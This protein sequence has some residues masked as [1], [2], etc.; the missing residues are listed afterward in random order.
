MLKKRR[1]ARAV[2]PDHRGDP[3]SA[4]SK[5]SPSTATRPPKRLLTDSVALTTRLAALIVF[6]LRTLL[7]QLD[8]GAGAGGLPRADPVHLELSS[9]LRQQALGAQHH[10]DHQQEAE[11]PVAELGQV[12]V[13]ADVARD[14]VE[15]VGDQVA[16][17]ER[18]RH[19]A[20]HDAPDRSEPAEDDHGE[21]EDRERELEL[22]GV[23]RVQIGAEEGAGDPA[24]RRAGAVGRELRAHD[25]DPHAGRRRP[26]PRAARSTPARGASRAGG[27]S[28][29]ARSAPARGRR[30]TTSA[31]R[32]R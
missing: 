9:S 1:L 29:T 21:D 20:Q 26:R 11:D 32:A 8:V 30:S 23:D 10:H 2:G 31:G 15:H 6:G 13:E 7:L 4:S 3:P 12:E 17:D 5:S 22:V 27:S 19:R 24:E 18:Q 16:V 25:R 14:P 28:R